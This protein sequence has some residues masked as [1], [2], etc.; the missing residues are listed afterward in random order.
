VS[1]PG[2]HFGSEFYEWLDNVWLGYRDE[3]GY[4]SSFEGFEGLDGGNLNFE[5]E[6]ERWKVLPQDESKLNFGKIYSKVDF[7]VA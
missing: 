5:F 4:A 3:F 2:L 6:F 7:G 1:T